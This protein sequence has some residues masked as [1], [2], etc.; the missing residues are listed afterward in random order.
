MYF[1][2][3]LKQIEGGNA[4]RNR[5]GKQEG[6]FSL[7]THTPSQCQSIW[8]FICNNVLHSTFKRSSTVYYSIIDN[9]AIL[10]KVSSNVNKVSY[11][12]NAGWIR[13]NVCRIKQLLK[14]RYSGLR[15]RRNEARPQ[16]D[17]TGAAITNRRRPVRDG[18]T[19]TP[20]AGPPTTTGPRAGWSSPTPTAFSLIICL[21]CVSCSRFLFLAVFCLN[22]PEFDALFRVCF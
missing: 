10:N 9:P 2:F 18:P 5:T 4:K 20:T 11:S 7:Y 14:K 21:G 6:S 22:S 3:L 1:L 12:V 17:C 15:C 8:C 16:A 13:N 19:S